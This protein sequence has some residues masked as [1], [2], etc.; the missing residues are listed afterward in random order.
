MHFRLL[1]VLLFSSL[2]FFS[3]NVILT[4]ATNQISSQVD[5]DCST[6]AEVS[7]EEC[8]ALVSLYHSTNGDN[9]FRNFNWLVI[10][11]TVDVCSWYGVEC[12]SGSIESIF[13]S[14]NELSGTLPIEIGGLINLRFFEINDNNITGE[15]PATFWSL[16]NLFYFE[17]NGNSLSG[18]LPAEIKNLSK[19]SFFS[20]TSNQMQGPI[21]KE[22]G[23]LPRLHTLKLNANQFTGTI[24]SELGNPQYLTYLTLYN[25]KLEGEIPAELSKLSNIEYLD[26]GVNKLTGP[27]PASL[28]SLSQL[29]QLY[30]IENQLTGEIP[31][32]FGNLSNLNHLGLWNNNLTGNIPAE[33]GSLSNLILLGLHSNQLDG[34]IPS[35]IGN[36]VEVESLYL[37]DNQLNGAIPS[38]L[39]NLTS[40]EY[41]VLS[42][43]KLT[44][45]LPASLGNLSQLR[46]FYVSQN[47]LVGAIPE[48]FTNLEY[49][50]A[51]GFYDTNICIDETTTVSTWLEDMKNESGNWERV[52][53]TGFICDQPKG[54]I[55][56]R[57]TDPSNN[58]LENIEVKILRSI[59]GVSHTVTT[60]QTNSDGVYTADGLGRDINYLVQFVD[61][62]DTYP[63]K[64]YD[65]VAEIE[66]AVAVTVSLG[67]NTSDINTVL[68]IPS[69]NYYYLN[70]DIEEPRS[71]SG[72]VVSSPAGI[73][74]ST[75]FSSDHNDCTEVYAE[76]SVITLSAINTSNYP[77]FDWSE[78]CS[79]QTQCTISMA[80]DITVTAIF[81]NPPPLYTVEIANNN[82]ASITSDPSGISC[83]GF[84]INTCSENFRGGTT[85][86]LTA[87]VY[88]G[89]YF[90]N[91]LGDC[92]GSANPCVLE[93]DSPKSVSINAMDT[94]P[95]VTPTPMPTSTPV[96]TPTPEATPVAT[97]PPSAT[98]N[99]PAETDSLIYLPVILR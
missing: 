63:S 95:T 29:Q 73:D 36:L 31:S 11:E 83:G 85:V 91:W 25:N 12:E 71:N 69:T 17:A 56:G 28:G 61:P 4:N 40:L 68:G 99:P 54:K 44:G 22:L 62:T 21:P 81:T 98:P 75:R 35:E 51:F 60:T 78:P 47:N 24:P 18:Q 26:L 42:N 72:Y 32:E 93:V 89:F 55:S 64:Y 94:P 80:E 7:Q 82:G 10:D 9:W 16:P 1:L 13:L 70:V 90:H 59:Q 57:I 92:A 15:L 74:C 48:E 8:E 39:G 96:A 23:D 46:S 33:L 14:S 37:N 53:G 2:F 76:D 50:Y 77:F 67:A 5:I 30:L 6:S 84:F 86:T 45:S 43:N 27:I 88:D 20:L 34:G 66:F 79:G 65:N 38:E 58:N 49:L 41:F 97:I 3:T 87:R 19:L 52:Q